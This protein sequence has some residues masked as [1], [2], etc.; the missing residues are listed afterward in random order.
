M[1]VLQEQDNVERLQQMSRIQ[2]SQKNAF[3]IGRVG[4]IGL[5]ERMVQ[6]ISSTI[7]KKTSL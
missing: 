4:D 5:E 3:H 1:E 7:S 2:A 6:I